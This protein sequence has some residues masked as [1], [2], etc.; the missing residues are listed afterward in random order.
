MPFAPTTED[1]TP[2]PAHAHYG[3]LPPNALGPKP[4]INRWWSGMTDEE[5]YLNG[6]PPVSQPAPPSPPWILQE[7]QPVPPVQP[8]P[9]L[10][11][12]DLPIITG[13]AFVGQTLVI[14]T[15]TWAPAPIGFTYQWL[16]DG[17]DIGA[18]GS[19]Y[20][21]VTE[22]LDAFISCTVTALNSDGVGTQATA[23][24]VGPVLPEALA[25]T[26]LTWH[27]QVMTWNGQDMKWW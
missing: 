12:V 14:G 17:V 19:V 26:I 6:L 25:S 3:H 21:L 13:G 8:A 27:G 20:L 24:A 2:L 1:Q 10:V 7:P 15:G 18:I 11:N 16:R 5:I 22:D 23:A 4:P 9:P